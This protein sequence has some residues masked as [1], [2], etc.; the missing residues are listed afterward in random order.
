MQLYQ[1]SNRRLALAH[2]SS[3]FQLPILVQG[4]DMYREWLQMPENDVVGPNDELVKP[5]IEHHCWQGARCLD[6]GTYDASGQVSLLPGVARSLSALPEEALSVVRYRL[7]LS[8]NT[9][10]NASEASSSE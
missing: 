9:A 8:S 5:C 10:V 1:H 4:H 6:D 3:Q 7:D 2:L